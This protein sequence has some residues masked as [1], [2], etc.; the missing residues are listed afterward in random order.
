V[1]LR[2]S[3][4]AIDAESQEVFLTSNSLGNSRTCR[5]RN[6]MQLISR[7][8]SGRW[9]GS[10]EYSKLW[11]RVD[12]IGVHPL[13]RSIARCLRAAVSPQ[14]HCMTITSLPLPRINALQPGDRNPGVLVP[15]GRGLQ[16]LAS[17]LGRRRQPVRRGSGRSWERRRGWQRSGHWHDVPARDRGRGIEDRLVVQKLLILRGAGTGPGWVFETRDAAWFRR[18]PDSA[19]RTGVRPP[20]RS[21]TRFRTGFSRP[22]PARRSRT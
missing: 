21:H 20:E 9:Y 10:A 1:A 2:F 8:Q 7:I 15:A 18:R 6:E 17:W 16:Q 12:D 13:H 19:S 14:A 4:I 11:A 22:G 5:F 3:R